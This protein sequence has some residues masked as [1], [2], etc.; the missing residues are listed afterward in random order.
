MYYN[1][2]PWAEV[3]SLKRLSSTPRL[4]KQNTAVINAYTE[5]YECKRRKQVH[6]SDCATFLIITSRHQTKILQPL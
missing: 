6:D 1:G 4:A 2:H 3:L 5:A